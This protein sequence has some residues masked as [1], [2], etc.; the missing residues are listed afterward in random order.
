[1]PSHA[2][3]FL[4]AFEESFAG[5]GIRM[6]LGPLGILLPEGKWLEAC[7][8]CHR[9]AD[10]Y[11]DRAL[12]YREALRK[13]G[14]TDQDDSSRQGVLLYNMAEQTGDRICL[15]NQILQAF[16]ASQE[17]TANLLGNIFFILARHPRVFEKLRAEVLSNDVPLDYN[18]L[19]KM[20]Y[21]QNVINEGE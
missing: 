18:S 1:M 15:R 12:E 13:N 17:T 19:M 21:L 16:M 2:V 9:F 11:V 7:A 5:A 10:Y 14:D 20:K 6:G 3:G 8:K 4:G